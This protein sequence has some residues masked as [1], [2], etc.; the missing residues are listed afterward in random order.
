MPR[1]KKFRELSTPLE[2]HEE[3][4]HD[5]ISYGTPVPSAES[6]ALRRQHAHCRSSHSPGGGGLPQAADLDLAGTM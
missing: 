4:V 3:E 5:A 1:Q 2:E 6:S